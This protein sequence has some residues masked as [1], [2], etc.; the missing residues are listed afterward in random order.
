MIV[1]CRKRICYNMQVNKKIMK[2]R[3]TCRFWLR[4][5]TVGESLDEDI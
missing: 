3:S 2:K 4:E 5:K 1:A